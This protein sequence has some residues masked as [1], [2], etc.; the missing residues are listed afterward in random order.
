[1]YEQLHVRE[2]TGNNDADE[3]KE[4]LKSVHLPA[5]LPYCYAGLYYCFDKAVKELKMPEAENPLIKTGSTYTAFNY[6]KKKGKAS[7]FKASKYDLIFWKYK[8]KIYGH[9]ETVIYVINPKQVITIGFNTSKE[10]I[11][12][13]IVRNYLKAMIYA[14]LSIALNKKEIDNASEIAYKT[15]T[16]LT[17][18]QRNGNGV[19]VRVRKLSGLGN[20]FLRGL[21]GFNYE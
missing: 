1:M 19:F 18:L 9:V 20:M 16:E 2:K 14:E 8:D 4:Y 13:D 6:L 21:I 10:F 15:I 12:A 7:E 3:I 11:K 5:K 17:E